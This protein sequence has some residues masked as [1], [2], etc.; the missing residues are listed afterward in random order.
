MSYYQSL[1]RSVTDMAAFLNQSG[2]SL[3]VVQEGLTMSGSADAER[4]RR[5][6][7]TW[8]PVSAPSA[9]TLAWRRTT[10][11]PP[12]EVRVSVD[13]RDKLGKYLSAGP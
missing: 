13:M 11:L 3:V 4:Q 5:V 8:A 12:G 1:Y 7:A 2:I 9:G 6:Q 10:P